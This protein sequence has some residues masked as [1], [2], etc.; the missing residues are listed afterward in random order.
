MTTLTELLLEADHGSEGLLSVRILEII[1]LWLSWW[2]RDAL[3]HVKWCQNK[4]ISTDAA[5]GRLHQ[6]QEIRQGLTDKESIDTP[7]KK[8]HLLGEDKH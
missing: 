7:E 8:V 4:R 1:D 3:D 6:I 5:M 2:E